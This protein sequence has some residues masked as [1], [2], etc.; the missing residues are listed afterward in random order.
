MY[1]IIQAIA[2]QKICQPSTNKRLLRLYIS[3]FFNPRQN[4]YEVTNRS[5]AL[6]IGQLWIRFLTDMDEM[7]AGKRMD[8]V[9]SG[10]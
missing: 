8:I 5:L 9:V 6:Y 4:T 1:T 2:V 7:G 10:H 3:M